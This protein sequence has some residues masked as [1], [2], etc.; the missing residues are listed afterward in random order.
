[1]QH[2]YLQPT[3]DVIPREGGVDVIPLN[4]GKPF[5]LADQPNFSQKE[6]F[7][8][9]RWGCTAAS[10]TCRLLTRLS[11]LGVVR[12]EKIHSPAHTSDYLALLR[13]HFVGSGN[14][15]SSDAACPITADNPFAQQISI[16]YSL[17]FGPR[18]IPHQ[19][20]LSCGWGADP[21][22]SMTQIKAIVEGIE[23]YALA[24][25]SLND[26]PNSLGKLQ[27]LQ[28]KKN[29]FVPLDALHHP[30]DYQE[31]GRKPMCPMN[32]S[33]VAG[34]QT[35]FA[36][37]TNAVLELCEHEALMVAWFGKRV[38][39]TIRPTSI[40]PL[41]QRYI[42]NLE[43]LGWQ[44]ILKDISVD[45]APVVMAIALGPTGKR[46]LTIGS[47]AAFSLKYA[48]K[49]ALSEVIR[50]ILVDEATQPTFLDIPREEV[51]DVFTHSQYYAHHKNLPEAAHLWA[52]GGEVDA[53]DML[54][55]GKALSQQAAI[56][57]MKANSDELELEYVRKILE[58]A[59]IDLYEADITPHQ[60]KESGV[61]LVIMR[62][63]A[64]EMAP[65]AVGYGQQP[66]P[67]KRFNHLLRTFGTGR[68]DPKKQLHPFS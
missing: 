34:H 46:A 20:S 7:T 63:Y 51:N 14:L 30:V 29:I 5:F 45:L 32:L 58:K 65:L 62:L 57:E 24:N 53:T 28:G 22:S 39:P 18:L 23:R 4:A 59:E 15:L 17:G 68:I 2:Y 13:S 61:P 56:W 38:T 67:T 37:S 35:K 8:S 6:F 43:Q 33:G 31:L 66:R 50:T 10:H 11:K 52:E 36:A 54:S 16:A 64:P 42:G 9:L 48:V 49:K 44:I 3:W 25:Y 19:S 40:D 12:Y 55:N 27:S 21:D 47:C 60:V 41:S 1:M 26:F